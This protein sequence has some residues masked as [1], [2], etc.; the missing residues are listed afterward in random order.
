MPRALSGSAA[1]G[2]RFHQWVQRRFESGLS[3]SAANEPDGGEFGWGE[4]E[5]DSAT[6]ADV[7]G[8]ATGGTGELDDEAL[9]A[10]CRAFETGP[11]AW[12][13]PYAVEVPFVMNLG[14]QQIRGRVDIVYKCDE[15]PY[16]YQILDWKTGTAD[17][18]DANQ[19]AIYRLAW[20]QAS[21]CQLEEIDAAFYVVPTGQLIRPAGL[22]SE[23]GV[24]A[25][26]ERLWCY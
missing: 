16:K 22:L 11:F 14:G 7:V 10:L 18:L 24:V 19:L 25:L 17:K 23:E 21:S 20:A 8:P 13:V 9:A 1:L 5:Y 26:V 3:Q 6:S 2:T 15:G 4:D 12:R